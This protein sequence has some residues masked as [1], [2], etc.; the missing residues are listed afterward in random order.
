MLCALVQLLWEGIWSLP[1]WTCCAGVRTACKRIC[2][3]KDSNLCY[4][5]SHRIGKS[6][7][8]NSSCCS[9]TRSC[10]IEIW[11]ILLNFRTHW[12]SVRYAPFHIHYTV[13]ASII[14]QK[15]LSWLQFFLVLL[16]NSLF[17]ASLLHYTFGDSFLLLLNSLILSNFKTHFLQ[18][19]SLI[20]A[21]KRRSHSLPKLTQPSNYPNGLLWAQTLGYCRPINVPVWIVSQNFY[22]LYMRVQAMILLSRLRVCGLC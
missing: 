4:K 9:R 16:S 14:S 20:S 19:G 12:F 15:R 11:A 7:V 6:L 17:T 8:S 1:P 3:H 10:V 2:H 13:L 21:I 5:Y 18:R 22:T